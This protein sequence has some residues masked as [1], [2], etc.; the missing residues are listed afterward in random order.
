MFYTSCS[1][2]LIDGVKFHI[3]FEE[4]N[5]FIFMENLTHLWDYYIKRSKAAFSLSFIHKLLLL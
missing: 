2:T 3:T 1:D 5:C 4:G